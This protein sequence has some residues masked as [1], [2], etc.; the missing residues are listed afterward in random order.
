MLMLSL[1]VANPFANNHVNAKEDGLSEEDLKTLEE[2]FNEAENDSFHDEFVVKLK[3]K[4]V[5]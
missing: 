4:T 5:I 3:M 1:T 2:I